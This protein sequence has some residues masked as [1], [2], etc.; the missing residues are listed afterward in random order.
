[1]LEYAGSEETAWEYVRERLD[2]LPT[3]VNKGDKIEVVR[4]REAFMLFDRMIAYHVMNG[5]AVPIDATDF[6]RGLDERF[7]KRDGMYFL[8]DQINEYD[9]ARIKAE[10]EPIQ[11]SLIITDEKNAIAWLYQQL[12]KPQTYSDLQPKFVKELRTAKFEIIPELAELLEENFLKDEQGK[13]YIP[14][15]TKSGDVIKLREKRLLKEFQE[16]FQGKGK[17]KVFR[18]EAVRVGFAKL[19][20]EKDYSNIIKVANRLPESVIQED[21]K[22]LMY[23]DISLS[24]VE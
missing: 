18:T 14:D 15:P 23:Y 17:L 16:Y 5:I 7:L 8:H 6:Y 20:K 10:I 4:E 24:R 3:V 12:E 11:F 2:K 21:E 22:L 9:D 1:M 13:W 19:F